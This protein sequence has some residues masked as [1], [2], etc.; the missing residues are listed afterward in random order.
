MITMTG[1]TVAGKQIYKTSAE[2]MTPVMLE[3]GGKAPMVVMNDA[4]LDKAAE[5]ALWGRFANCGQVC[6]CVERLYLH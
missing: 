4:D 1:S 2:Y 5:D 3:L 6:T